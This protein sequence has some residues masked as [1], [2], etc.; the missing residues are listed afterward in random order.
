MGKAEMVSLA[1]ACKGVCVG[2]QVVASLPLVAFFSWKDCL[3]RGQALMKAWL[4][5]DVVQFSSQVDLGW[6]AG[7]YAAGGSRT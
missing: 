1:G 3:L 7:R 2:L 4:R 5:P 6:C